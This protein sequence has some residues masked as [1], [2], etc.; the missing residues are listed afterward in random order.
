MP[1]CLVDDFTTEALGPILE[2]NPKGVLV[3]KDELAGLINGLNQYKGGRGHDRQVLLS[4]WS[5]F[6]LMIDRKK[7][8]GPVYVRRPFAAIAGG[9]QPGVLERLRGSDRR[10]VA[11]D[12][13]LDRL[14]FAYP[15]PRKLAAE[16]WGELPDA[17]RAGWDAVLT[18]LAGLRPAGDGS[19]WQPRRLG[20]SAAAR[21]DWEALTRTLAEQANADDFPE[22]LRG[23]WL[24]LRGYGARLALVV[25]ALRWAEHGGAEPTEADAEA[26]RAAGRLVAWFQVQAR[27]VHSILGTDARKSDALRIL[28]WLAARPG[29]TL[30]TRRDVY[31]TMRKSVLR[32]SALDAPLALL[33]EH[34]Y[35]S[36]LRHGTTTRY[37]VN[38]LW[39]PRD[40]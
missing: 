32:P 20:L 8:G 7:G 31:M 40:F 28:R 35:L 29:V 34:R 10:P 4:L 37:A 18:R 23:P 3:L 15:E 17:A 26:V 38:P 24:K 6:D 9:I 22:C 12:G 36:A 5:G 2:A 16:D 21:R 13:L 1:R 30:F 39:Q 14:L 25:A 19:A 33:V 11:D 27:K